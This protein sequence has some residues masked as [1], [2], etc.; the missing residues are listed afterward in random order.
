MAI[1]SW[2]G[3]RFVPVGASL[4]LAACGGAGVTPSTSVPQP[5]ASLGAALTAVGSGTASTL[6]WSSANA[7]SC[8]ASGGWSGALATSGSKSTGALSASTSYSLTCAGTGGTSNVASAT[9]NVVPAATVTLSANPT[10]VAGGVASTLTWSSTNATSCTASGGWSGALATSGSQSTGALT[11]TTSYSLTCTGAGGTSNVATAT[12]TV[13]GTPTATFA[14]NPTSVAGGAAS[15]LTWSSTNAMSCTASGGWSGALATSGSQSTGA[16]TATTSYSLTCTGTGGTSNVATATVSVLPA[17]TITLTANPAPIASGGASTLTWS[18]TNA[19][20]CTA[21]GSWS[22]ALG[23]SGSQS[24][25]A[26]TMPS[27]YSLTC[28]GT[29]GTSGVSTVLVKIVPTA[30]VVA[31]P[32]VVATGGVS[33]LTWS[34][35]NATSCT[36]SGGWSGALGASG[37]Q[38]TGPLSATNSYSLTCSGGGGTS[39][40]A[41]ATVTIS[42]GAVT[43]SPKIA[44]ITLLQTQQFTATVPGGGAATWAVDGI[45][46]GNSTVGTVSAS[47]LYTAGTAAGTHAVVATSV[48]NTAQSGSA[49]AAVTDLA[50]VYTYHNDLAR[51][52]ANSHEYALT[53]T[54]VKNG[55]GKLFACTVDGA[56]YGQPLWVANLTVNGA[57]HNVVFVATQHDSLYAFDADASPCVT[58]WSVSLIDTSHG[59]LGGETTVPSGPAGTGSLVGSGLGDITPEVGV[60]GTP[61]ID[62][63]TNTLYVVSKSVN[64]A[65]TIFYQRLHAIDPT[66][67][68]EKTGSPVTIAGTFPGTGDGGTT[69]AFN[70]QLNNQRCGLS[71]VNGLVYIA[72]SSHEDTGAY[73]GWIMGYSY[74]GTSFAQ[75]SVLNVTPNGQ[76][77]GIWMSGGAMAADSNNNLYAITGNGTFDAANASAPNNDYGD[78]LLQLNSSLTVSQYFTP[79]DELEDSQGDN[80]FGAGGTTVLADLPAGSNSVTQHL[81]M[82]GGKDGG[83]YV[84]NRDNLGGQGD[85][86]A[87]QMLPMNSIFATGAFWNNN[88]YIAG[89]N[90]ALV[91]YALDITVPKFTLS[92]NHSAIT[93]GFPG[94]TPS[95]SA[96]GAQSGIVWILDTSSYCTPPARNG[97]GPAVLHAYDATNTATELWNSSMVGADAPGNAV[98]FAVP[99]VAN[100]KVYVGT[101]GNNTG[102]NYV[103]SSVSGELDVYGL[104]P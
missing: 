95:V 66:T 44:A 92:P 61:V 85:S 40:V 79:T 22:G 101:R 43:L 55:F 77:G 90:G 81:I 2:L 91:A 69:I 14:A 70:S 35:T 75:S 74:N 12:V 48:A 18:S 33:T 87:V 59:G 8:A 24:T 28:T 5:T 89:V 20:S 29:G 52:G 96:A 65:T 15:T 58:L 51:D 39:S 76:Q 16:L 38:G 50:G 19:T 47:G 88:F 102:G 23:T 104:K 67:G 80:D 21:S 13:P 42:N 49:V 84:L 98:K 7:T 26:L 60:T 68:T 73:H 94:G 99:T 71:L 46:G 10:S 36:A 62:P 30:T 41:S 63:A 27:S 53:T 31:N 17:P 11:A 9:V 86:H 57:Q 56:I 83:L 3:I 4:V 1:K 64:S 34:S 54:N 97:C 78:S 72:W 6:I 37:S 82:G 93:Y 45:A 25:G 32:S 103:S 100:G